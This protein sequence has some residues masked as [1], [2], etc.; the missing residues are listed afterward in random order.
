MVLMRI[1]VVVAVLIVVVRIIS[2][3]QAP[4]RTCFLVFA[5]LATVFILTMVVAK[6]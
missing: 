6:S 2:K 5:L 4:L 1:V 3:W